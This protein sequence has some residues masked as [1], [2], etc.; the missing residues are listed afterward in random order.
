[1]L[2]IAAFKRMEGLYQLEKLEVAVAT[3][4]LLRSELLGIEKYLSEDSFCVFLIWW[5]LLK[6]L[7]SWF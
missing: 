1:M 3:Q 7:F 4:D 5:F 6:K 2:C